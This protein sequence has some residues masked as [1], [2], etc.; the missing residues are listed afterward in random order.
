MQHTYHP[1]LP[2]IRRILARQPAPNFADGLTTASHLGK[3]HYDKALQQYDTYIDRLRGLGFDVTVLEADSQFPD[4]HFVEDPVIIYGDMAFLCRSGANA[5][6]KEPQSLLPYLQ[7]LR[8]I[9]LENGF[10]DGGDVLFCADR[11]LVGISERTN[12]AGASALHRALQTVKPDIRLDCV[13]FS[14]VLHLKSGLTELAPGVLLHDPALKTDYPLDWAE[15]IELPPAEGY[16]A[17]LRMIR[18]RGASSSIITPVVA[19]I[20]PNIRARH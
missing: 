12:S 14:G 15:V 7:N 4:G 18:I 17:S 5:R 8:V 19:D 11:V 10:M 20:I 6:R 1:L 13:S 3:P 16:G 2:D 9:A